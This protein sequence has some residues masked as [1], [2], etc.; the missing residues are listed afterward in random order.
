MIRQI[1]TIVTVASVS[2]RSHVE[3]SE[4]QTRGAECPRTASA[5]SSPTPLWSGV[6]RG[7]VIYPGSVSGMAGS[8][9]MLGHLSAPPATPSPDT[10]LAGFWFPET[11]SAPEPLRRPQGARFFLFPIGAVDTDGVAHVL[12]AEP[13]VTLRDSG[14]VT[15]PK[16]I[17]TSSLRNGNWTAP[18][19]VAR[20]DAISWNGVSASDAVVSTKGVIHV[21]VPAE[22]RGISGALLH[23]RY[24]RSG[25]VESTIRLPNAAA[26]AAIAKIGHGLGLAFVSP[27]SGSTWDVNSVWF[28]RSPDD[29]AVWSTPLVLSRSGNAGASQPK[30]VASLGKLHLVW[31]QNYTGGLAAE[32]L[33]HIESGDDGK[34]WSRPSDLRLPSLFAFHGAAADAHGAIHAVLTESASDGLVLTR[35]RWCGSSWSAPNRLPFG[36]R[37]D[38]ATVRT[39]ANGGIEVVASNL[40]L[41]ANSPG[42]VKWQRVTFR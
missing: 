26:Y 2:A 6:R 29:G 19:Q 30:L 21:V 1:I 4:A 25:W 27:V 32:A 38:H 7:A 14:D 12:W 11:K 10:V 18:T 36:S 24:T 15:R 35:A 34:T 13:G 17:W 37:V 22:R 8:T 40:E 42:E 5:S 33:R 3:P 28:T 9:L 20:A 23:L 31:G 16:S 39:V 41:P